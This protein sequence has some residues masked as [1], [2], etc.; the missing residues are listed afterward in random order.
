MTKIQETIFKDYIST[1]LCT[2]NYIC[3]NHNENM[4]FLKLLRGV[5]I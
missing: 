2:L 5:A 3:F 1:I 4:L